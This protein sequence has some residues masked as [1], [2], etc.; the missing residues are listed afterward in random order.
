MEIFCDK[1]GFEHNRPVGRRCYKVSMATNIS[2]TQATAAV[3]ALQTANTA[4]RPPSPISSMQ[5]GTSGLHTATTSHSVPVSRSPSQ[6]SVRTEELILTELQKLSARMSQVEQELQTDTFT[7]TPRKRKKARTGGRRADN[8]TMGGAGNMTENQTTFEE[9]I[10]SLQHNSRIVV[11]VHTQHTTRTTSVTTTSLFSQR[12]PVPS[13]QVRGTST[14]TQTQVVFST[15]QNMHPGQHVANRLPI[16]QSQVAGS[17]QS[18]HHTEVRQVISEPL[19]IISHQ[20]QAVNHG[21]GGQG[22]G[23]SLGQ[24]RTIIPPQQGQPVNTDIQYNHTMARHTNQVNSHVLPGVTATGG[25]SHSQGGAHHQ[26]TDPRGLPVNR[27]TEQQGI[28]PSLQALRTTAVNQDLVQRRLDELQQQAIPQA[29]GNP[30][31]ISSCHE[32]SSKSTNH[33]KGK[34]E[35][36]EVVWPQDCAFVG[37]L[38]SRVTYEQLTQAQFVL[39]YLRSVHEEENPF[40]R[41]NM[42]DYLT[43][44]FQNT[45]DFGWQAA[46]GAHL[47]VMTK[48]EEGLVTWSDLKKV[49][50]IRK[51][52]VRS[53]GGNNNSNTDNNSYNNKKTTRKP[54][55]MPC[56]DFQEGKCTKQQDHEVGLITHKHICAYCMYTLNRMYGHSENVCNNKKRSKNG[57]HPHPQQ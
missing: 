25:L 39:G 6:F 20:G 35:K 7:S 5:A 13:Q 24:V 43:E 40:I 33:R 30:L 53:A 31:H 9:S 32:P 48:M 29:V 52:Y 46:K 2:T 37:H 21:M 41:A 19:T 47:V 38:R 11:P 51:T 3:S 15:C 10:A 4:D 44:L 27:Q 54:S 14:N 57:Q 45:C 16:S 36:V 26:Q 8:S 18:V 22:H 12:N 49:N 42:V 50:R 17:G 34:K 1:C 55:S 23:H 56:R 28:I